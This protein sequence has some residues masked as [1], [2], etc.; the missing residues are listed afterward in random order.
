MSEA[1]IRTKV[2]ADERLIFVAVHRGPAALLVV[3]EDQ[4]VAITLGAGLVA[5]PVGETETLEGGSAV[6]KVRI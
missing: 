4:A 3:V 5:V 6:I 1:V 2:L